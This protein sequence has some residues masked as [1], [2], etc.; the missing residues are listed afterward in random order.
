MNKIK[1]PNCGEVFTIDEDSYASIL[2]QIK[3]DEIEKEV[4]RRAQEI[5]EKAEL[6]NKIEK[7]NAKEAAEKEIANLKAELANKD[8]LLKNAA[9][10]KDLAVANAIKTKDDEIAKAKEA[11]IE[12]DNQIKIAEAEKKLAVSNAVQEKELKI[13]ELSN[14]LSEA[15]K[16]AKLDIKRIEEKHANEL[17]E[18]DIQIEYF[19]DLKTKMSTKLLGETL[20]Q[21]CQNE[22]NKIRITAFPRAY[23]EKDNA[24]SE[25][26]GSKGDYIFKD[27]IDGSDNPF[28]SIMFEMK[29]ENDTTATKHKNE[30]FFKE[31]DKDRNEKG[32]EYAVLVSMLESDNEFYNSGIVDVSYQ[33]PKMYVIRPQCFISMITLLRN[34]ALNSIEYQKQVIQYKEE[35]LD[36]TNFEAAVKAVADKITADYEKAGALYDQVDK[37]CEDMIKKISAFREIF[38]KGQGHIQAAQNQLENLSIRKLTKNNPTMKEKFGYYK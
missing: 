22:F 18:K 17:K 31:L 28:I 21:H 35:H 11:I 25:E 12:K 9:T 20:E 16:D 30:H 8:S 7:Q 37:M 24:V 14:K 19:K 15:E 26:S 1:C 2:S 32:C 38:R 10:E 23:F 5:K 34:A 3:N 36:I 13:A 27:F 29:N 4:T 6:N 33:Y